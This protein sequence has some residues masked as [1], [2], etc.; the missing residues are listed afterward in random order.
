M[1]RKEILFHLFEF[2]HLI[3]FNEVQDKKSV[4]KEK[5]RKVN[6]NE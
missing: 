6:E 3:F 1:E 2:L 4:Q 5:N